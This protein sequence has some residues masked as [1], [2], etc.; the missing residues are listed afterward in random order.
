MANSSET[1]IKE[2]ASLKKS[3]SHVTS[4]SDNTSS[5]CD[6]SPSN[7]SAALLSLRK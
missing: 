6:F 3:G 2:K 7:I 4:I 1:D 5:D